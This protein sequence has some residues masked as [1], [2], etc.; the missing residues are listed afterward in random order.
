MDGKKG[1]LN[2][3]QSKLD[4][5]TSREAEWHYLQSIIFYKKNW[6]NESKKQLE[7]ALQ[8]DPHNSKY[9][10]SY[11]KLKEK[12]EFSQARFHSGNFNGQESQTG[13]QMGGAGE[14]DCCSF[15]TTWCCMN[16]LCNLCCNCR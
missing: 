7:I 6:V 2:G 15:C 8:L 9:S 14:N 12:T 4:E 5:I 13:R 3:A 10:Q 1:D 11:T 16:M